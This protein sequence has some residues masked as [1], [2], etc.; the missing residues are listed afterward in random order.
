ME[1]VMNE[2]Y[3]SLNL[4]A[5]PAG[6]NAAALAPTSNAPTGKALSAVGRFR[7]ILPTFIVMA[8]LAALAYWGHHT[9]W[10]MPSFSVLTANGQKDADVWCSEHG[11]PE[12]V[13][14][15][16][17]ADLMPKDKEF[18]WCKLHGVSECLFE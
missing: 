7:Q 18:G 8:A 10:T 2:S 14:V 5:P 17:R 1:I 11:V 4:L 16:C 9:G 6:S 12:S 13:C 3:E 15:E